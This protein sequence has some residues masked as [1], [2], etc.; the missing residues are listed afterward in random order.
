[1]AAPRFDRGRLAVDGQ[2]W[3]LSR[4][5][6]ATLLAIPFAG[7]ALLG[8]TALIPALYD[9][10]VREDS[11]LEWLQVVSYIAAFLLAGR[12]ALRLHGWGAAAFG[13]FAVGSLLAAGEELSWGQRLFGLD[14]PDGLEALNNQEELNVHDVVEVQGKVNLAVALASLYGLAA[15]WLVQRRVLVV[16][17]IAL[18]SAFLAML[19]YTSARAALFSHPSHELAKFSEWP[20]TCFACALGV[21]ALLVWRRTRAAE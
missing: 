14:T 4:G 17:P 15:P 21:F 19:A 2:F 12:S 8:L 9:A 18:G 6:S 1:M 10:L 11:L 16:P 13:L 20:E 7:A 3:G 5:R